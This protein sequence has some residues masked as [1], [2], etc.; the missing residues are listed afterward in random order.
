MDEEMLR[1]NRIAQEMM[2][3]I[4]KE[5][6]GD[7]PKIKEELTTYLNNALD[8]NP[9]MIPE[10]GTKEDLMKREINTLTSDWF[11]YLLITDPRP[12]LEKVTCPV[13]AINGSLDLQV[14]SKKNLENIE[15][16]VKKGGN[17][18]VTTV[19]FPNLNHLFQTTTTG[20]PSEYAQL[21]E[22]FSPDA[23]KVLSDWIIEKTK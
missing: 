23:L 15:K 22:T 21:E 16:S 20:S 18:D 2:F 6:Y 12:T 8:Q 4:V 13:L 7:T 3:G 10:G 17:T 9:E 11:Q 5:Y 1:K 19:E 14:P